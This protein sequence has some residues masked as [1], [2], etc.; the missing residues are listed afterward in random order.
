MFYAG[1][2]PGKP[3]IPCGPGRPGIPCLPGRP[4]GP[5]SPG[6]QQPTKNSP[7]GVIFS[8][9]LEEQLLIISAL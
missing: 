6:R 9:Y 2:R 3:G 7:L 1:G 5:G 4:S 8:D